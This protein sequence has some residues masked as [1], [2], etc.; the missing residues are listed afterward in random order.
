MGNAICADGRGQHAAK[1]RFAERVCFVQQLAY[2]SRVVLEM[3][4]AVAE[5]FVRRGIYV[6]KMKLV[7]HAAAL[8][9]P[10]VKDHSVMRA[11]CVLQL[12][13]ANLV[14]WMRNP[15]V[16]RGFVKREMCA[17]QIIYATCV[18][19]PC[20]PAVKAAYV[21]NGTYVET[22]IH[23][24]H[25]ATLMKASAQKQDARDGWRTGTTSVPIP[26]SMM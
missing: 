16:P 8:T 23:A 7:F 4:N 26:S 25:A 17:V 5:I 10:A 21:L 9:K 1:M 6:Q 18:D 13:I 19:I 22:T 14:E 12:V 15:A 24:F 2:A 11:T 20:S 3:N